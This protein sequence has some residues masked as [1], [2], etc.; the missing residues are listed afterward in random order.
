[1]LSQKT[2]INVQVAIKLKWQIKYVTYVK[3]KEMGVGLNVNANSVVNGY[4]NIAINICNLKISFQ[5][6]VNNVIF[7]HFAEKC[8]KEK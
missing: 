7:V 6:I 8:R 4:I 5:I 3:S 2:D 1:M